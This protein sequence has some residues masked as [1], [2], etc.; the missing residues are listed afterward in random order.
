MLK[1]FIMPF[2]QDNDNKF[3]VERSDKFGGNVVYAN[4]EQIEKILAKKLYQSI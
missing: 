4:Y 3:V 2:K 1:Y